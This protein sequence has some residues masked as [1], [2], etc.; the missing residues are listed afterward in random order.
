MPAGFSYPSSKIQLWAPMR[1]DPSN[2]LEYWAGEF[3]PL[4]ARLRSGATPQQARSEIHALVE[5]FRKTFPYP[6]AR[7]WKPL[8]QR[9]PSSALRACTLS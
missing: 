4:V 1:L 5:R 9:F 2:V 7:G 8:R 6:M 3:I